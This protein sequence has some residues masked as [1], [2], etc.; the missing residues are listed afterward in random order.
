[1]DYFRGAEFF[2]LAGAMFVALG[3]LIASCA[4]RFFG[5]RIL[6]IRAAARHRLIVALAALP[7]LSAIVLLLAVS[8][9]SL[10]ALAIPAF[11]HC[12]LHDDG[13]VHLCFVHW[14]KVGIHPTLLLGLSFVALV[15]G[16]RAVLSVRRIRRAARLVSAL[17]KTGQR[18]PGHFTIIETMQPVCVAAGLL[19]P[20]VLMSRGLLATLSQ[21]ELTVIV[22]HESAHARRKD[23]FVATLVQALTAF[24]LPGAKSW[25]VRELEVSAEEA[26]DDEAALLVRDRVTVASTILTVERALREP[27]ARELHA[28]TVAFGSTAIERRVEAL[29]HERPDAYPLSPLYLALGVGLASALVFAGEVHHVTESLL[30]LVAH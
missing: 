27:F 2:L 18:H 15:F 14:P 4:V 13:H 17:V 20:R 16:L 12:T 26:C 3:S 7:L 22:A 11:D 9:P 28:V 25:L 21:D 6:L 24:H 5:G 10:L 23:A 19:R 29:L 8:L 30:S 1:M